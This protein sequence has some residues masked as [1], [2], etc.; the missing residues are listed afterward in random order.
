MVHGHAPV[1][2]LWKTIGVK[3]YHDL[4]F[5]TKDPVNQQKLN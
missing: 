1:F 3:R 2:F 5:G 4:G